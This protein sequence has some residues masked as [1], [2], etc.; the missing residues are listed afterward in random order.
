M[1]V[2]RCVHIKLHLTNAAG[3]MYRIV[4]IIIMDLYSAYYKKKHRCY[5]Y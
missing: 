2:D 4:N 5:N 1:I 3:L